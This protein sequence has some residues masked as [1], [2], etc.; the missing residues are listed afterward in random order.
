MQQRESKTNW[1]F[2]FSIAKSIFRVFAGTA[3]LYS[4]IWY[5]VSAGAMLIVAEILGVLEEL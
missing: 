4:N 2:N 5:L 3:L 1:H